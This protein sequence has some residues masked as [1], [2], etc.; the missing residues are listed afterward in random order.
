M[1]G[2][3]WAGWPLHIRA[4]EADLPASV[5][6]GSRMQG[7]QREAVRCIEGL[8]A[9]ITGE[10]GCLTAKD[11]PGYVIEALREKVFGH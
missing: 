7:T 10:S 9:I 11:T 2:H 1:S 6:L 8:S 4:L 5:T 3:D